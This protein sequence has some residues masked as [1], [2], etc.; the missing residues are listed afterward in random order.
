MLP[1]LSIDVQHIGNRLLHLIH[2]HILTLPKRNL[3][4][5]PCHGLVVSMTTVTGTEVTRKDQVGI[6]R[7]P[8]NTIIKLTMTETQC[9]HMLAGETALTTTASPIWIKRNWNFGTTP[10][11]LISNKFGSNSFERNR[12]IPNLHHLLSSPKFMNTHF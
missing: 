9:I 7:N 6:Q 4:I 11:L 5:Q 10:S 12:G 8:D 2:P 3:I 1:S